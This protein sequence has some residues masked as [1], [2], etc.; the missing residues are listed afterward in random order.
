MELSDFNYNL[1][2]S[3]IAQFPLEKRDQ[4][5]LLVV[6]RK[7]KTIE[8]RKFNNII[9]YL[10]P[11]DLLILNNT[12]VILARLFGFRKNTGGKVEVLLQEQINNHRFKAL[13]NPLRRLKIGEE[14]SINNN[15]LSFRLVDFSKRII[16][17]SKEGMLDKLNKIGHV[18]LPQYIK[19]QDLKMDR[20]RYQTVYAEKE[21]SIAAPT[22]GLH[23]T[24]S[25]LRKIQNK[26]VNIAFVTLH[27][28]Y[29][30]FAPIKDENISNHTMHKEYFEIPSET[31]SLIRQTK[32]S[33]DRVVAV[34]TTSCRAL[35]S[36]KEKILN[37]NSKLSIKGYTDLF[38]YPPFK[39]NI[40]D[41][42]ITNFHLPKSTLYLLVATFTGLN[43]TKK[44]YSQ[45]I[46]NKYRFYSYGDSMVIL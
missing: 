46:E 38:I 36:S 37:Q 34:G 10:N 24:K 42:L 3:L 21:G 33:C 14:I 41:S 6:D 28:G 15:G 7:R 35:E 9:D 19:R 25:L 20:I 4:S 17:F 11:G 22:A 31:V 16:E 43:T 2:K 29:G 44:A 23:F 12:K 13:I 30:T 32:N 39:F 5:R 18:P 1:P 45:A 40:I 27:V 26:G 8:H